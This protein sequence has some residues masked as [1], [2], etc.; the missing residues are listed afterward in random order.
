M[1]Y[2][3]TNTYHIHIP[4]KNYSRFIYCTKYPGKY[5]IRF[6]FCTKRLSELYINIYTKLELI[7][8]TL[9]QFI[10]NP[11][12]VKTQRPIRNVS[13]IGKDRELERFS[14]DLRREQRI[15]GKNIFLLGFQVR[16]STTTQ[17]LESI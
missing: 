4:N 2:R 11:D 13:K 3:L 1:P 16:L 10:Y 12:G 15:F 5:I 6:F 14:L 8:L 17:V 9:H 7:L